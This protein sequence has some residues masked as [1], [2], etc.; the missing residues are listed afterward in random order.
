MMLSHLVEGFL[1]GISLGATCLLTCGPVIFVFLLRQERTLKTSFQIFGKILIGRFFGYAIFGLVAGFIGGVIP[2]NIRMPISYGSFII[3]GAILIYY[4]IRG[5]H[6]S[7]KCPAKGA[8]KYIANPIILGFITGLEICPPFLLAIARAASLGGAFAGA[9]LFIGFFVGT[10]IFLLPVAFFGA[11]SSMKA[12]RVFA[13]I[14]SVIVGMWFF[15]QGASGLVLTY[16]TASEN[17]DYSI[18]GAESAKNIWIVSDDEWGDSLKTILSRKV[19]CRIEKIPS[20]DVDSILKICDTL[21]IA[22]CLETGRIDSLLAQKIAVIKFEGEKSYQ[23]LLQFSEFLTIYS[24][25]KRYGR[26]FI[27]KWRQ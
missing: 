3:L 5:G 20:Q 9:T 15:A 21:D 7:Q 12:F 10:S 25:K 23:T 14:A 27:F 8:G 16:F 2:D 4:G 1:L 11:A 24:F 17:A 6:F 13:G 18:V 22:L 19:K 26:G